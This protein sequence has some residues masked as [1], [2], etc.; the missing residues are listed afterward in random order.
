M[1]IVLLA[2]AYLIGP[3]ADFFLL[4][5]PTAGQAAVVAVG[6]IIGAAGIVVAARNQERLAALASRRPS[7]GSNRADD[8]ARPSG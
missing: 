5:L 1:L 3:L 8:P 2:G 4:R 6:A 7:D